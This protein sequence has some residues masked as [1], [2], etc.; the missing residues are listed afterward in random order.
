MALWLNHFLFK[1][2]SIKGERILQP[3]DTRTQ[4][5]NLLFETA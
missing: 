3:V 1:D 2:D 4:L 5:D